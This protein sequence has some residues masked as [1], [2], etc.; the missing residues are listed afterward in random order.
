VAVYNETIRLLID[1]AAKGAVRELDELKKSADGA[2]K[3]VAGL[4]KALSKGLAEGARA[5]IGVGLVASLGLAAQAY[6]DAATAAGQLATM[7]N[8]S[9]E[10]ASRFLAVTS[11]Y[12]LGMNDIMEIFTD[13]QKAAQGSEAE[14]Q[15]LGVTI[16]KNADGTTDWITTAVDFL[17]VMQKIPD[18]TRRNGLMIKYFGDEGSKQLAKLVNSG[19]SVKE[20]LE[21]ID[22]ARVFGTSDVQAAAEYNQ[23]MQDL[24]GS[25]DGLQFAIG[26]ALVPALSTL[27]DITATIVGLFAEFDGTTLLL[28]GSAAALALNAGR[29]A[30]ILTAT[31]TAM[32]ALGNL[33]IK[34]LIVDYTGLTIAAEQA[35]VAVAA[36]GT[37][38]K[39]ATAASIVSGATKGVIGVA[40]AWE[41]VSR[42]IESARDNLE[43]FGNTSDTVTDQMVKDYAGSLS[44]FERWG[45]DVKD[46]ASNWT[47][48]IVPGKGL[49]NGVKTLWNE[50]FGGGD[51]DQRRQELEHYKEEQREAAEAAGDYAKA[52]LEVQDTQENLNKL[53]ASGTAT[54]EELTDALNAVGEA[55]ARKAAIDREAE[56]ALRSWHAVNDEAVSATLADVEAKIDARDAQRD[57]TESVNEF[58]G[59]Q[60]TVSAESDAYAES[61]DNVTSSA[62][63]S[64]AADVEREKRIAD[65]LGMPLTA[66]QENEILVESLRDMA[67]QPGVPK[68]VHD[69]I[70]GIVTDLETAQVTAGEGIYTEVH[71]KSAEDIQTEVDRINDEIESM[72]SHGVPEAALA[73]LIAQRDEL[74]KPLKPTTQ[75]VTLT[76]PG[77]EPLP[78][79]VD[80]AVNMDTTQVASAKSEITGI[81]EPSKYTIEYNTDVSNDD[82]TRNV[83]KGLADP[84][85][86]VI[87]Y[88][89]DVTNDDNTENV[90]KGLAEPSKY[91]IEY[92]A[93]VT[94]EQNTRNVLNGLDQDRQVIINVVVA[95][96]E[97]ARATLAGLERTSSVASYLGPQ[98]YAATPTVNNYNQSYSITVPGSGSP[99]ITAREIDR[100]IRR[101]GD[102]RKASVTA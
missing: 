45:L 80:V 84:K 7:T 74:L 88:N 47:N 43:K 11:Q 33:A 46:F 85:K 40:I 12:G 8:S 23:A 81:A 35:T 63:D 41:V 39:G 44:M 79:S 57:Y 5:V 64:A 99:A 89:T 75:E 93:V 48:Y 26:R 86:Y 32:K 101:S 50:V 96:A 10:S 14:L 102:P 61:L 59:V 16:A 6:A 34:P 38:A 78:D 52:S 100:Y 22:T 24:K 55:Q 58:K 66:A 98:Q 15:K 76:G 36:S 62:L 20:S 19:K 9:V 25:A 67:N 17:D 51:L 42:A 3:S 49:W 53:I 54:T 72:L 18:A 82:N 92:N 29:V 70:M 73:P 21:A 4:T 83:L 2:D 77:G 97:A 37:A 30:G 87:E 27:A 31:G 65:L 60:G 95:G 69:S 91:T 68:A 90:L 56:D 28:V 1:A 13:F 71:I 94:N